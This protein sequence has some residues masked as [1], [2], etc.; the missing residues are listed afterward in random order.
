MEKRSTVTVVLRK[1]LLGVLGAVKPFSSVTPLPF[2]AQK[3][4]IKSL[5]TL[6][7]TVEKTAPILAV[8]ALIVPIQAQTEA[9]FWYPPGKVKRVPS[10]YGEALNCKPGEILIVNDLWDIEKAKEK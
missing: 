9:G 3:T 8:C 6:L 5:I 10:L 2:T 4:E 1:W 7:F